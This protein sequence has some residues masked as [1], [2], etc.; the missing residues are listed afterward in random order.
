M[1]IHGSFMAVLSYLVTVLLFFLF[2][3]AFNITVLQF[4]KEFNPQKGWLE[5][6]SQSSFPFLLAL[7]VY[8]L[9]RHKTKQI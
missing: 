8:I 6:I 7:P 3:D 1:K 5:Y 2:G 9:V 4:A